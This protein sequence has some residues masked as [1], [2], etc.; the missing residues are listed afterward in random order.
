MT[1]GDRTLPTGVAHSTAH[2]PEAPGYWSYST[3]RE[4][5]TCPRRYSLKHARYPDL[6][7]KPGYPQIPHP[8]ALF[9]DIVHDALERIIRALTAAGCETSNSDS[10]VAVLRGIGGYTVAAKQSLA[11]QMLRLEGNPRIDDERRERLQQKL[12]DRLAEARTEIQGYLSRM[13][14]MPNT[15]GTGDDAS[16]GGDGG[17]WERAVRRPLGV[18][19][20]PEAVLQADRLRLRGRVDLLTVT[21]GRIDIVD[22]K[23]GV[24]N[25]NHLDQLRFYALL[26]DQDEI[27]NQ[28]RTRLGTLTASYPMKQ[29][30]I[31]APDDEALRSMVES[32]RSRV[33]AADGHVLSDR[34][35]ALIGDHCGMCPV[36]SVCDEYWGSAVPAAAE[37]ATGM[38]FDYEGVV[39][40][41]N[42]I[43]S[44]WLLDAARGTTELLLRTSRPGLQ[45]KPGQR[46]RFLGLRRDEDPEVALIAT[47]TADS[48]VFAVVQDG[49]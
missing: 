17:S 10:A 7:D 3:L 4:I 40:Q 9:G 42:G 16:S 18:G 48:E 5:E 45:L 28:A 35:V 15:R 49:A 33:E 11:V 23:T 27:A 8:A 14:L 12:E 13:L 46:L 36:R 21:R 32:T 47:L 2:L 31:D 26:W 38:W 44:W 37:V 39:G 41:Q 1:D 25:P 30:T 24:E 22:H 19:S 43:K 20:H 29:V 34:P 6:W